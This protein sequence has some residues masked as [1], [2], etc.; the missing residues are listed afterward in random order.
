MVSNKKLTVISKIMLFVSTIIWG[1]SFFILKNTLDEVPVYFLLTVRFLG[2]AVLMSIL[3]F[4]KLKKLNLKY[5]WTGLITGVFLGLAYI[6]QTIG[7]MNTTPGTNAFLTTVY[8]ILVPFMCWVVMKKKPDAFNIISAVICIGG[9]GLVCLRGGGLS[10]SFMGEGFTLICGIFFGAQMVAIEVW[11]KDIDV[12]LHTIVQLFG[13]F[14]VCLIFFLCFEKMPEKISAAAWISIGYVSVFAT[15]VTFM[16]MSIG[17]KHTSASYSSL[18]LC[19]EAVFGV[20]FSIVFYHERLS[21]QVAI[22]FVI[23]FI[24]VVINE[25]KLSFL[26]KKK[27]KEKSFKR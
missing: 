26:F 18:V 22:G 2:A 24:G 1:S 23:I 13:A 16:F 12:I 19:L 7:L 14:L 27:D 6:F 9:I 4:K 17:I 10:F 21:L 5:I 25:T 20:F 11:C 15:A 8:C 3:C